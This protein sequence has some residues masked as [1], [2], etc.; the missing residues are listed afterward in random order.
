MQALCTNKPVAIECSVVLHLIF[1]FNIGR[2][3][4]FIDADYANSSIG[5]S[6]GA[7]WKRKKNGEEGLSLEENIKIK[8][9]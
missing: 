4:A 7:S 9:G 8:S 5:R 1:A 6:G 2:E 3:F